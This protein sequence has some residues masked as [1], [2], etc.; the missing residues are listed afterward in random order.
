MFSFSSSFFFFRKRGILLLFVPLYIN[1]SPPASFL[2]LNLPPH[3]HTP[4][5]RDTDQPALAISK[6]NPLQEVM[7]LL[8]IQE[9]MD[10]NLFLSRC[11]PFTNLKDLWCNW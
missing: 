8:S 7:V 9:A 4:L 6:M 11:D 1:H 2:S 10:S 5:S 3:T